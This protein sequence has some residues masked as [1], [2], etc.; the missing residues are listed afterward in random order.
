MDK[1]EGTRLAPVDIAVIGAGIAGLSAAV[2]ARM[3][4]YSIRVFEQHSLPGGLC[5][6]WKRK[7]F[8]FDYSVDFLFGSQPVQGFHSLWKELGLLDATHFRH[9]DAFGEYQDLEGQRFSLYTDP[10]RLE[11]HAV[12]ISP[13]D[14]AAIHRFCTA[15]GRIRSF[16]P[17]RL[18]FSLRDVPAVL[19]SLPSLIEVSRWT[20]KSVLQWSSQL[21]SPFLRQ[22][23]PVIAG[24]DTPMAALLLV[25]GMMNRDGAAC[26]LGGSLRLAQAIEAHAKSL[27]VELRYNSRVSGIAYSSGMVS[28]LRL[29]DGSFQPVR[30]LVSACDLHHLFR[31]LLD[32]AIHVPEYESL[33]EAGRLYDPVVQVSIGVR[34][35]PDWQLETRPHNLHLPAAAGIRVG[36]KTERMMM[37]RHYAYDASMAPEGCTSLIVRFATDFD[38]WKSMNRTPDAYRAEKES[39]LEAVISALELHLPGLRSRIEACDVATPLSAVRYTSVWRGSTQGWLLTTELMKQAMAGRTLPVSLPGI[40]NMALA[41]QWTE[42]GGGIPPA[43]RSGKSAALYLASRLG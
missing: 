5:T 33:F 14:R 20:R 36:P 24:P 30:A 18:G 39:L 13:Q 27:G 9:I 35:D 2:F 42:P 31:D 25:M 8:V 12:E 29:A 21:H 28:G 16:L 41:G 34:L 22:A 10:A 6:S 7:G 3:K 19:S 15:L 17:T 23:I 11:R 32:D 37:L 38:W 26:P 1:N 43:A 40:S 4:G